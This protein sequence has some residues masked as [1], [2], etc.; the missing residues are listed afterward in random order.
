M[1]AHHSSPAAPLC[2][3]EMQRLR[4][5]YSRVDPESKIS[6]MAWGQKLLQRASLSRRER[7]DV[8]YAAGACFHSAAIE[9]ALSVRCGRI[10]E[11]EK[12][13]SYKYTD[14]KP[15]GHRPKGQHFFKKKVIVKK[16]RHSC[17]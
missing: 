9:K 17:R 2:L 8:Y 10:H 7:H 3:S 4:A 14:D 13:S 12:R 5:Q 15:P 16:Q 11:D 6:D 1:E